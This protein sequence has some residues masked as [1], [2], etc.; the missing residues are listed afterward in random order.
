[1][2]IVLQEITLY[3]IQIHWC[4]HL[5]P[6]AL[7]LSLSVSLSHTHTHTCTRDYIFSEPL[8]SEL[9]T[10]CSFTPKH[11]IVCFP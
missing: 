2:Q 11:S 9:E 1:M 8:E 4:L 5:A 3:L 7:A 10:F 6:V